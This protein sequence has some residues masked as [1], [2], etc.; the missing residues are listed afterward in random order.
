VGLTFLQ[1]AV[2]LAAIAVALPIAI[3]L[4]TRATRLPMTFPSI[5]FLEAAR[6]S[7]VS[8]QAIEDWPLLLLRVAVVLLAVAALA[9]PIVITP[10]REA[11]WRSRVARAVVLDDRTAAPEDELRSAAVSRMFARQRLG[12]AVGDAVRWLEQQAP[13]T[14]ELVVLSAFRRGSTDAA[15][16]APVP[17]PIGIRLVRSAAGSSVREREISRLTWREGRAVRVLERLTLTP[18]A[19]ELRELSAVPLDRVPVRVTASPAEQ[20]AADAALRAVLRRGLRL[21]PAGLL[22]PL[23]VEWPGDVERLAQALEL[24]LS[25]PMAAW[26]PETLSEAELAAITRAPQPVGAPPPVDAGDRRMAWALV[27]GLLIAE[28]WLRTGATWR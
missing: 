14:R 15:D 10:A 26:E 12:D 13:N 6:L 7:A 20:T 28:L 23:T 2:W 25:T 5:R 22:E 8:R 19:T 1:P 18:L 27:I 9:G 4:L 3:H 11:A 17:A 16:F 21:P 24:R